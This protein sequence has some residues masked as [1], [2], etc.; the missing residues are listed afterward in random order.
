MPSNNESKDKQEFD[1]VHQVNLIYDKKNNK[2]ADDKNNDTIKISNNNI[3]SSSTDESK[4][5]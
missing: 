3:E 4:N 2:K 5:T 1:V